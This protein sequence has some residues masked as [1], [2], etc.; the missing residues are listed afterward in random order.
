MKKS[1]DDERG[2]LVTAHLLVSVSH[3]ASLLL[4][5]PKNPG[6]RTHPRSK[7]QVGASCEITV[8]HDWPI[9]RYHSTLPATRSADIGRKEPGGG[10]CQA[11]VM[12][13]PIWAEL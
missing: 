12:V 2:D 11:L 8:P 9:Q 6:T 4:I 10:I 3:S 1:N 7:D 13:C 5:F